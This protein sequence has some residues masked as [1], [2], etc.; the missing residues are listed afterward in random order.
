MIYKTYIFDE[1]EETRREIE[2]DLE[3]VKDISKVLSFY[4]QEI[5]ELDEDIDNG[6]LDGYGNFFIFAGKRIITWNIQYL[7]EDEIKKL[8]Q[9]YYEEY[10]P[11]IK[12]QNLIIEIFCMIAEILDTEGIDLRPYEVIFKETENNK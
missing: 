9:E 8:D 12:Q 6:S 7:D 3:T 10:L 1:I 5:N 2:L 11:V 4:K